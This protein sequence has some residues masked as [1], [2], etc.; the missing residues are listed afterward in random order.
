MQKVT[1][2]SIA[3]QDALD[4][5]VQAGKPNII[6]RGGMGSNL[7]V[8]L[9]KRDGNNPVYL[10]IH[11]KKDGESARE[12]LRQL[13]LEGVRF[14]NR[15]LH[16][17]ETDLGLNT[18][19]IDESG[20]ESWTQTDKGPLRAEVADAFL[21]TIKKTLA[22]DSNS[23]AVIN[24]CEEKRLGED[25]Y[26]SAA[27]IAIEN[28]HLVIYNPCI[29]DKNTNAERRLFQSGALTL[30][31]PNFDEFIKFSID[32]DLVDKTKADEVKARLKKQIARKDFNEILDLA[33]KIMKANGYKIPLLMISLGGDGALFVSQKKALYC[34]APEIK[35]QATS[36][37]G[38]TALS[39]LITAARRSNIS[40]DVDINDADMYTLTKDF[41]NSGAA[42]AQKP[43]SEI[44]GESEIL[45][46]I[47]SQTLYHRSF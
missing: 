4:K 28:N 11:G 23:I 16:K 36:A 32:A 20:N 9:A 18:C 22:K 1:A 39:G 47:K 46:L 19:S 26:K 6:T 2:Y 17:L 15:V 38:D 42:T 7:A 45:N 24:S 13:S 8:A 27:Q 14:R 35:V 30:A 34:S 29:H 5:T 10:A 44:A 41:V 25:F 31:K 43:G 3:P 21:D 37:A 40:I 33:R 12:H